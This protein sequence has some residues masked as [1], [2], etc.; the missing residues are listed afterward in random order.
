MQVRKRGGIE[1]GGWRG[2]KEREERERGR[3]RK[4]KRESA[5]EKA[6]L[7]TSTLGWKDKATQEPCPLH[8]GNLTPVT[9]PSFLLCGPGVAGW[10]RATRWQQ[11]NSSNARMGTEPSGIGSE[12]F[13]SGHFPQRKGNTNGFL[14][15]YGSL[16]CSVDIAGNP[17]K[18]R[19]LPGHPF[20]W[21]LE[22]G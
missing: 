1:S 2:E 10:L 16:A 8:Q 18:G 5:L 19:W 7:L 15:T 6:T 22:A 14:C 21:R 17:M 13:A 4:E 9:A 11:I 20:T 12:N 3:G